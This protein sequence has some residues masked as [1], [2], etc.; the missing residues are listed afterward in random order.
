MIKVRN[1][2]IICACAVFSG[3]VSSG[4]PSWVRNQPKD[5]AADVYFTGIGTSSSGDEAEAQTQAVSG[6][7]GEVTRYIGVKISS[8][9][10]VY[11]K[12]TLDEFESTVEQTIRQTSNARI[13]EFRVEDRYVERNG[14]AVTVYLLASYDKPALEAEKKRIQR[15]F[16]E[17]QEAVSGPELEGD[18]LSGA[19]QNYLA[20]AKYIEAA[21]AAARSDIDNKNIKF[22][23]N[24]NK[25]KARLNG[26]AIKVTSPVVTGMKDEALPLIEVQVTNSDGIGQREVPLRAAYRTLKDRNR[27][28][29]NVTELL[30]D[31]KGFATL[32]LPVPEFIGE[33]SVTFSID[34]RGPMET[35]SGT[36]DNYLELA[37]GVELVANVKKQTFSYKVVSPMSGMRIVVAA[38]DLDS[39]GNIIEPSQVSIG[40][41]EVLGN[42]DFI[43]AKSEIQLGDGNPSVLGKAAAAAAGISSG[44]VMLGQA[45]VVEFSDEEGKTLV[46]VSG[47]GY[48]IDIA[49]GNIVYTSAD[50]QKS[51]IGAGAQ[52]ALVSAFRQLGKLIAED[53]VNNLR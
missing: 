16:A 10:S 18:T 22:E 34:L 7:V 36:E 41:M 40:M 25:A 52:A 3:C 51:A 39:S 45:K 9:V 33:E 17:Q 50:F 2:L 43:A 42:A 35:F 44:R 8:D 48:L 46:K 53:L 31:T 12:D 37:E 6:M 28:T 24:I 5:T 11:A 30:T 27:F 13:E 47:T 26:L 21:G 14:N 32:K 29:T 49:T 19:G 23:R 15:I 20:V 1:I 4:A 38:K